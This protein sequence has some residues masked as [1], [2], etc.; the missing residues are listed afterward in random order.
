VRY[1]RWVLALV[2]GSGS[3]VRAQEPPALQDPKGVELTDFLSPVLKP[4]PAVLA[5]L[6]KDSRVIS[7]GLDSALRLAMDRANKRFAVVDPATFVVKDGPLSAAEYAELRKYLSNSQTADKTS[8][9]HDPIPWLLEAARR[10][11]LLKSG[12]E[13]QTYRERL[14]SLYE[15]YKQGGASSGITQAQVD[16]LQAMIAKSKQE[17]VSRETAYRDALHQLKATLGLPDAVPIVSDDSL[18][19]GISEVLLQLK[20]WENGDREPSVLNAIIA[21]LPNIAD[22]TIGDRSILKKAPKEEEGVEAM[23]AAVSTRIK[24]TV[25]AESVQNRLRQFV[26]ASLLY[27]LETEKKLLASREYFA[28]LHRFFAPNPAGEADKT[29]AESKKMSDSLKAA[30]RQNI[31]SRERLTSLWI[32]AQ[33]L[34]FSLT[35][36]LGLLPASWDDF[37]KE[38]VG[39]A[40]KSD[41][42]KPK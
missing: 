19:G 36:D 9:F 6:K 34:R 38:S 18:L 4:D 13:V 32:E 1:A 16:R 3:L 31:A 33:T 28:Q 26:A 11:E 7:L 27:R 10:Q 24:D 39:L 41:Q 15:A 30:D 14:F 17:T 29:A 37:L 35:R 8:A 2:L 12:I 25:L 5:G 42:S 40:P 20:Q 23:I 22:I 21:K